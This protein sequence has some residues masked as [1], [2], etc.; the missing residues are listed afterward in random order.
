M[1]KK[2]YALILL[3]LSNFNINIISM[4]ASDLIDNDFMELDS[5][6]ETENIQQDSAFLK[7]P[8]EI[9]QHI[10][11]HLIG[12]NKVNDILKNIKN[13]KNIFELY[14]LFFN[15]IEFEKYLRE[16]LKNLQLTV[17][18]LN[19]SV[20]YFIDKLKNTFKEKEQKFI[21][22]IKNQYANYS[23]NELNNKLKSILDLGWNINRDNLEEA[24]RLIIAGADINLKNN[25]SNTILVWAMIKK[26]QA[27]ILLLSILSDRSSF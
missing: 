13:A 12:A 9:R 3:L 17:R 25:D 6:T 11:N 22:D 10:I 2:R 20:Q 16:N 15:I 27:I 26:Y 23:N 4:Q 1:I 21:N 18:Q 19:D 8:E 5:N 24:T 14:S 7:L